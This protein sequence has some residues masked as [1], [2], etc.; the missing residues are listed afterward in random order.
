MNWSATTLRILPFLFGAIVLGH[1]SRA[2]KTSNIRIY[3]M[4]S[5]HTSFPDSGRSGGHVYDSVLYDAANH[6]SDNTVLMVVPNELNTHKR[7]D[8]VF[9][10]HGWR[11]QVDTAL[12]AYELSRQ[13]AAAHRNAILV[14]AETAKNAPDSYG[15]KLEQPGEF[16]KLRQDVLAHLEAKHVIRKDTKAGHNVIAGHSGAY[17]VIAYILRNGQ[18]PVDEVVLFDALYGETDKF[19]AWLNADSTHRLVNWYTD[20]GGGTDAVS[21]DL[22]KT[23]RENGKQVCTV[24]EAAMTDDDLKRCPLL[25]VHS[26]RAHNDII[27]K[28]DNFLRV[29][30][31]SPFLEAI[32]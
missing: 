19:L 30:L 31:A 32:Q 26:A 28:P 20:H 5:P 1:A 10:F 7:V 23:L 25:F 11:N 6:Y 9:W 15:G 27:N 22:V 13:W 3:T 24:E 2:Q 21:I 29:L 4:H 12:V 17:R 8:F 14:L 16:R 18:V